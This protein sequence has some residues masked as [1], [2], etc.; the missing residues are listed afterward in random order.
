MTARTTARTDNTTNYWTRNVRRRRVLQGAGGTAVGAAALALVGCGDD[1]KAAV[2][3]AVGGGSTP[4]ASASAATTASAS[5]PAQGGT[6]R[7]P[8]IGLSSGNPPTIY[9]Y[10]A[11]GPVTNMTSALHYSRLLRLRAEDGIAPGD[12]TKLE[13]DMAAKLPEQ[14]DGLTY[15]FTLKPNIK[16]HDKAPLNGRAVTATDLLNSYKVFSTTS[17]AAGNYTRVID[18][19]EALDAK[20]IKV[21][22]K[23]PF[24]PFL[25]THGATAAGFWFVPVETIDSGQAKK[26]PVGTGPFVFREW[27]PGVAIRWDRHPGFHDSPRPYFDKVEASLVGDPQRIMT[28]LQ[29]GGFDFAWLDGSLWTEGQSKLP[30][31][32]Q[33]IVSPFVTQ[34]ASWF[35]F[36]VKQ[37]ADKRVRQAFS[38][39]LDRDGILKLQDQP[40]KG[41][42]HTHVC[43]SLAPY[44]L[45]PKKDAAKFGA[46]A[47]YYQRNIADAKAL[48]SAAGFPNG[49]TFKM[50]AN[51]DV[52][53][54]TNQQTWELVAGSIKEAGFNA[55]LT[56]QDYA[57]YTK[58]TYAGK[59]A[60]DT[61]AVGFMG[62]PLDP[63]ETFSNYLSS[64]SPT[65]LWGGPPID[66]QADIDA[67]ILKQRTILTLNDRVDYIQEM[68]RKMA[69]SMISVPTPASSRYTYA[70]PWIKD[71]FQKDAYSF[72]AETI[73]RAYFTDERRKK[74]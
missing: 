13:G 19:F 59:I 67:M 7:A 11:I 28:G 73:A 43:A 58:T 4:G 46:N 27:E 6:V 25:T 35:N 9:P 16:F 22:L 31:T 71:F 74:G 65:H 72:W 2:S 10:E 18:K 48:L 53:G 34:G 56:Y 33:H 12:Y 55:Q 38:M 44:H 17:P 37:F 69:E 52:Y 47:K 50:T 51:V 23:A 36:N 8:L 30:A 49:F 41:D 61:A 26:D 21:T 42:Y 62:S 64:T 57:T 68:Q 70:Q 29:S 45:S 3:T 63:D 32:G 60:D 39:A 20:T 15:V 66:E 14:P 5:K 54:P 1:D 24:A 40:G